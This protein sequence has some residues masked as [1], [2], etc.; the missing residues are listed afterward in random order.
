MAIFAL[1]DLHLSQSGEKPM[2]IFGPEW[3]DHPG[4]I[5]KNWERLVSEDDLVIVPGDISWAMRPE[6]AVV[7]LNWLAT[8]PG[9]KLLVRGNHDYWW[10]AIGKVRRMLPPGIYALQNDSFS[11]GDWTICGTRGWIYPGDEGFDPE[12][13][14][15]IYQREIHR[16]RLSLESSR[17]QAGTDLI[18]ALHFPPFNK[19]N[20][21]SGFSDLM[22]EW[23]VKI[24][25]YGHVHSLGREKVFQGRQRGIEY[26]Y[27]AADGVDFSP[28][29][30]VP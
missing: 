17:S 7:D 27:V 29:V 10:G 26:Y 20:G 5:K 1:G 28:V 22:E 19:F 12:Y 11:W 25:L 3:K 15:R 21:S 13:D 4:K 8:L 14:Q 24:C 30:I 6:E 16:L 18:C 9:Q 23:G 2:D